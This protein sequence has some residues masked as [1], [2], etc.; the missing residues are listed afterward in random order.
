MSNVLEA[1][2]AQYEKNT[3]SSSSAQKISSEERL[4]MYFAAILPKGQTS[5]M[6]RIRILPPL[7]GQQVFWTEKYFH[8]VQ[9]DKKWVKLYDPAQDGEKSPLNE[10]GD[11]LRMTGSEADKKLAGQYRS[12]KFYI[13]RVIDR[14]NEQ[15][16][17]K[18]W[19]IK[20]SLKSDGAYNK[21]MDVMKAK[22]EDITDPETG[23]DLTLTLNVLK[24]PLG[25]EYTAITSVIPDDKSPLSENKEQKEL[26]L[27]NTLTWQDAYSKK[28]IEYLQGVAEGYV[29]KWNDKLKKFV[30]GEEA[31]AMMG[32]GS[33]TSAELPDPQEDADTDENLPF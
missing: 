18:F 15:D 9:V 17:V 7:E 19:R 11:A 14:D 28:P 25:G 12:R 32:G 16:G 26:W 27:S 8:E 4:K 20:H 23:R 29:P 10:V 13:F 22:R 1:A 3:Q 21:I 2:L 6:K 30:Y 33:S 24:N 5:G 31:E